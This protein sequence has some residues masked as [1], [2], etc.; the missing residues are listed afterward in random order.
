MKERV[1]STHVTHGASQTSLYKVWK[2]MRQRCNN[3]NDKNFAWYGG[4]GIR[5]CERWSEFSVFESDMGHTYEPGLT[6]DRIDN[7][8]DYSPQN[9]R[10]ATM[11]EQRFNRAN[12]IRIQTPKGEMTL[13]EAASAYGVP[14]Q[15][16]RHRYSAGVRG[17]RLLSRSRI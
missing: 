1:R 7:D 8:G 4:R 6:I 14:E 12:T 15:R 2:A 11:T 5:V 13:R 10:W 9:C 3:P 16:L 17:E